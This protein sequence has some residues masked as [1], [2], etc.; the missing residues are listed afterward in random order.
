MSPFRRKT[1]HY[2]IMKRLKSLEDRKKDSNI[3]DTM[4]TFLDQVNS[5]E[6]RVSPD[7][8]RLVPPRWLKIY[9]LEK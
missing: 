5:D 2:S 1:M 6:A 4:R 9:G 7:I 3:L 8:A